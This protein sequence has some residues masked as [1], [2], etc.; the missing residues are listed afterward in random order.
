M[1]DLTRAGLGVECAAAAIGLGGDRNGR[2]KLY[3]SLS[4]GFFKIFVAFLG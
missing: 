4:F 3:C 2:P 1:L